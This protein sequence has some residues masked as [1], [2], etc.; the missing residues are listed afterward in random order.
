[1]SVKIR[2]SRLG[3]R[4]RPFFRINVVD[5]RTPRDGRVLE[6]VGY[7]D[8]LVKDKSK[9]VVIEREKIES[10]LAKGAIPSDTVG[11]ILK[12]HGI[13]SK[14][15]NER[16]ARRE[17]AKLI[18]RKSGKPFTEADRIQAKKEAEAAA[19]AAEEAAKKAEEEKKKAAEEAAKKAEAEK[20][21]AE[22]E[23]SG[24][25]AEEGGE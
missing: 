13:E 3:R 7:Y 8:P 14:H 10:W 11:S 24:S 15:Y 19:A 1:M 17:R 25:E 2:M 23:Q 9:Q 16:L 5:G 12:K 20:K 22:A 4:H 18:A 21:E 6:N